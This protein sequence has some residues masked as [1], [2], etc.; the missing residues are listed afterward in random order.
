MLVEIFKTQVKSI[1]LTFMPAEP[2]YTLLF[3]M[4][5][6]LIFVIRLFTDEFHW[7][8]DFLHDKQL[9]LSPNV[10]VVVF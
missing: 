7:S 9:A 6:T 10:L 5:I 1:K 8:C 4:D 2:K 3:S